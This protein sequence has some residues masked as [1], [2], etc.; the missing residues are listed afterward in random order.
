MP[1]EDADAR[2]LASYFVHKMTRS[3]A[4][5]N[6][7]SGRRTSESSTAC[8]P[9]ISAAAAQH[10]QHGTRQHAGVHDAVIAKYRELSE[11]D[12]ASPH[13]RLGLARAQ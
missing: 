4:P 9:N 6:N 13:T 11:R 5:M 10:R 8:A 7:A 3:S 1:A 12:L 2:A